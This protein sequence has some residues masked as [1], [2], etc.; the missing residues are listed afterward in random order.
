MGILQKLRS[1]SRELGVLSGSIYVLSRALKKISPESGIFFYDWTVQPI[2]ENRIL[3]EKRASRYTHR[4]IVGDDPLFKEMPVLPELIEHR[5][6]QQVECL[7]LFKDDALVGF[8]WFAFGSYVEDEVRIN[9][10]LEPQTQSVFDFNL[11]IFPKYRLGY[12]F[13]AIWDVANRYLYR[14]GVRYTY[15]RIT[16]IKR[17]SLAS[18]N[19]L[20]ASIIGWSITIKITR[21]EL[22]LT[23][24]PFNVFWSVDDRK[25]LDVTMSPGMRS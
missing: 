14:H 6:R 9:F 25:R 7:A 12:A 8:I 1:T 4:I 2:T 16:H 11:Y 3:P 22:T 23:R 24:N 18:H 21:F 19:R 10:L 20:G 17:N 5:I 13:A 15:S